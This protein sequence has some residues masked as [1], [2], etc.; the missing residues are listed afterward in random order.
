M[1]SKNK[2]PQLNTIS[3]TGITTKQ[4]LLLLTVVTSSNHKL[5][6]LTLNNRVEKTLM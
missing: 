3:I 6:S 1:P 2:T 4:V 5:I